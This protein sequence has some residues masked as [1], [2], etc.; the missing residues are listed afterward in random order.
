MKHAADRIVLIG[1]SAGSLLLITKI[2]ESLPARLTYALCILIHR[3]PIFNTKIENTL[4]KRLNRDIVSIKDKMKINEGT[5]YFAPP[6]YHLLIE[7]DK[8]FALDCSEHV[9]YAKPSIDVLFETC[10]Q[11]YR[12]N[13]AAFLLSG[14]NTDGARGLRTIVDFGGKTFIQAPDEALI[15]TMPLSGI[16]ESRTSTILKNQDIICY[17]SYNHQ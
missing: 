3:S 8:T 16:Q 10:A 1:G 2:L 12:E 5:V 14:A 11:V 15:D 6:G 13:C 7:P 9:N 4:S 17:F